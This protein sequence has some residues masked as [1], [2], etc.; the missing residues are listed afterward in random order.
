MPRRPGPRLLRRSPKMSH[1]SP[2]V[3]GLWFGFL[4]AMA[5]VIALAF[6]AA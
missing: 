5:V 3:L 1:T 6:A 4:T 2:T